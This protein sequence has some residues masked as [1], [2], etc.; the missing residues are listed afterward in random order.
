MQIVN[1]SAELSRAA[2]VIIVAGMA[3]ALLAR[4]ANLQDDLSVI[5]TLAQAGFGVRS[6]RALRLRAT[7]TASQ[8]E[9]ATTKVH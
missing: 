3:R 7:L 2:Q 8:I 6:I 4:A 9:A 5:V 1:A